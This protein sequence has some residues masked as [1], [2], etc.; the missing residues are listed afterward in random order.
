MP[1]SH[2]SRVEQQI[3]IGRVLLASF[4]LVAVW[5]DPA[6]RSHYPAAAYG[7]LAAYVVYAVLVVLLVPRLLL[8][9]G[10]LQILTHAID[11][12]VFSALIY[13]TEGPTSLFFVLF[14]FTLITAAMRWQWRGAVWTT[15]VT[16]FA[17]SGLGML[18]AYVHH[19]PEFEVAEFV[20][21]IVYLAVVGWLLSYLGMHEARLRNEMD[22]LAV[23]SRDARSDSPLDDPR[24]RMLVHAAEA[25]GAPRVILTWEDRDEP[26]LNLTVVEAHITTHYRAAP[27]EYSPLLAPDLEQSAFICPD[28]RGGSAVLTTY[29]KEGELRRRR[30]MPLNQALADR[31]KMGAVLSARVR[32]DEGAGRLF[33]LDKPHLTSD[34]M[35]LAEVIAAGVGLL[36][37]ESRLHD[38]LR[39]SAAFEERASLARDL[40]DGVLQ[41][42][43]GSA[44]QLE[45]ARRLLETDVPAAQGVIE[46]VQRSLT[47]EQRDLR[48]F[49]D[50]L[51]PGHEALE[52]AGPDLHGRLLELRESISDRWNLEVQVE[53]EELDAKSSGS[54]GL[55]QD[56]YFIVREG[57]VNSA[58]HA[59]ATL[60]RAG[61]SSTGDGFE[62]R[63]E[64]NGRGFPFRG[65]HD[66]A[67]LVGLGAGPVALMQRVEARGGT[68]A[69]DSSSTGSCIEIM[70]PCGA[71]DGR[72]WT[73]LGQ[74]EVR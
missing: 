73:T 25:M 74:G 71:D 32:L 2:R 47:A 31:F 60:A 36:M 26:W 30:G 1:D 8:R 56:V 46:S 37:V 5:L 44:L 48:L 35:R 63:L 24:S 64:D 21:G 54:A 43:T 16:L 17:F 33:F 12:A 23:W 59:H 27:D 65:R 55:D 34:D 51:K 61:V 67:S 40:H 14:V 41:A 42:L 18:S 10:R 6:E 3:A 58:R 53:F 19:D 50:Q 57:L 15:V 11:I 4:A 45:T 29:N 22:Q 20:I 38:R 70:L 13:L 66:A 9:G 62:I 69:I 72:S 68:L 28:V 39:E 7:V 49:V 52:G